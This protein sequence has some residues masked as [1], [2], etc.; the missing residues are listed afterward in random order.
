M[1]LVD[2][3]RVLVASSCGLAIGFLYYLPGLNPLATIWLHSVA[4]PRRFSSDPL[5]DADADQMQLFPDRLS[6][7]ASVVA[8]LLLT[9]CM[10]QYVRYRSVSL[11]IPSFHTTGI[12]YTAALR[13]SRLPLFSQ[14]SLARLLRM[15]AELWLMA[16]CLQLPHGLISGTD[17]QI[18]AIDQG[19]NLLIVL[20]F[21]LVLGLNRFPKRKIK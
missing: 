11:P 3:V 17:L 6:L 21:S 4:K 2:V 19:H 1:V 9:V 18:I 14:Q 13:V 8:Y 15:S 5:A 20:C 12:L 16:V 7:I 10:N